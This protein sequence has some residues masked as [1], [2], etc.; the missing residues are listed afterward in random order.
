MT[1]AV[2]MFGQGI[3]NV[4]W[5]VYL[6]DTLRGGAM[7]YGAVQ[8]AVGLGTLAGGAVFGWVEKRFSPR[9]LGALGGVA[10]G[11]L[12]L[13]TFN[14]PEYPLVLLFNLVLGIPAMAWAITEK[15]LVQQ[16]ADDAYRGRVFS[17]FGAVQALAMLAGLG[18]A[19]LFGAQFGTR[20]LLDLAGTLYLTAGVLAWPLLSGT[21]WTGSPGVGNW[22]KAR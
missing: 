4:L 2:A 11:A 3:I 5:V 19:S 21:L 14:V 7:E 13:A 8:T 10:V 1:E 16:G 15:T 22:A 9:F 6:R 18:A 12:L 20:P 17:A